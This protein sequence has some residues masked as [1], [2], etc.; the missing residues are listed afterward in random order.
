MRGAPELFPATR[1]CFGN[2]FSSRAFLLRKTPQPNRSRRRCSTKNVPEI[3][4]NKARLC[5]PLRHPKRRAEIF[6]RV[7]AEVGKNKNEP[8][9]TV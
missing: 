6:R 7:I 8:R 2:H 4:V 9:S 1:D 5:A 3:V